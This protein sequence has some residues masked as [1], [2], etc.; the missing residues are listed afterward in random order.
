MLHRF[1]CGTIVDRI[2]GENIKNNDLYICNILI[3]SKIS[4]YDQASVLS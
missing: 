3:V 4:D 2:A 1:Q